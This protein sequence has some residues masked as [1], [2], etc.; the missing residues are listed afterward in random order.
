[1]EKSE[2]ISLHP[3][4]A[5]LRENLKRRIDLWMGSAQDRTT[6]IPGVSLHR[7]T[8]PTAPCPATYEPNMTVI[9]QGQKRVELGPKVFIYDESRYLLTS[10]D[11]PVVTQV[12]EAS[13]EVPFLALML[14]IEMPVIRDLLSKEEIPSTPSDAPAMVTGETTAGILSA[15]SRLV[16][17]LDN[18]EDLPFLSGLI[19]REIL[20]RI[21]KGPEGARLRTIATL[22]DQNHKDSQRDSLDQSELRTTAARRRS[23]QDCWHG[24]FNATPPLS[25]TYGDEPTSISKTASLAGSQEPHARRWCRCCNCGL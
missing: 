6:E 18:P 23:G 1:M 15:C 14:K 9:F 7:R 20:Y 22:G 13:E 12:I 19:Q 2:Q 16:D 17:L 5:D 24:R 21:L 4:T 11:L 3:L 8:A 25:G 10:L